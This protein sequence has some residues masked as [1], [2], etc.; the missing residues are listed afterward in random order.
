MSYCREIAEFGKNFC[1]T[2]LNFTATKPQLN[3]VFDQVGT[4]TFAYDYLIPM[5]K[6]VLSEKDTKHPFLNIFDS[7]FI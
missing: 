2:M 7:P 6:V 3:V 5:D 1:K 4:P